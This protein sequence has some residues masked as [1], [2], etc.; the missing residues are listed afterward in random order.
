MNTFITKSAAGGSKHASPGDALRAH[1]SVIYALIE[2]SPFVFGS[3]LGPF[4]IKGRSAFLP[5]FVFFGPHASDQSWRLAF[6]AGFSS[7]DSR[8]S[9][10]L[11][12]LVERLF[13]ESETGHGLHLA[14]FPVVDAGGLFLGVPDRG[15]AADHWGRTTAP[16]IKLLERDSRSQGYHGFI[17]IETAPKGES[18]AALRVRGSA[19][20]ALSPDLELIS[21]DE[22]GPLPVRFEACSGQNESGPLSSADDL[23]FTPFEL[24]L[25][26]PATW[27]DSI[28]QNAAS[29]LLQRFLWRYRAFQAYGQN[30]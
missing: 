22:T 10:A 27:P 30:L 2:D 4:S 28:Y 21:T 11:L 29:L 12:A 8:S 6:L 5:R 14:L 16:E 1:F 15:L 3:P 13:R 24:T 9:Q 18:I 7:S 17:R 26:L 20:D 23:P 25:S 19:V